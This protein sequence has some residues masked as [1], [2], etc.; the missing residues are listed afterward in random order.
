MD[1][2]DSVLGIWGFGGYL[3]E[4]IFQGSIGVCSCGGLIGVWGWHLLGI[5]IGCIDL[6]GS[7]FALLF[8]GEGSIGF[9]V[10]CV[11]SGS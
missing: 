11:W 5:W 8:G 6:R 4:L 10:W 9:S 7:F 1:F 2:Y 3:E